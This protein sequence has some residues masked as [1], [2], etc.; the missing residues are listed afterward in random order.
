[1]YVHRGTAISKLLAIFFHLLIRGA[2]AVAVVPRAVFVSVRCGR[3]S[4]SLIEF[5]PAGVSLETPFFKLEVYAIVA[6]GIMKP[7]TPNVVLHTRTT[8]VFE[9]RERTP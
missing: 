6:Q 2:R 7:F 5:F 8:I 3:L 4:L 1:M 9:Q